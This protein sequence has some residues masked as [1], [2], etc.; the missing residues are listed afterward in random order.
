ML[1]KG[2][3]AISL[4]IWSFVSNAIPIALETKPHTTTVHMISDK[5][6]VEYNDTSVA[7]VWR[8]DYTEACPMIEMGNPE[9]RLIMRTARISE[10]ES[11]I[12]FCSLPN[13]CGVHNA[14][15]H[16]SN[17]TVS[18]VNPHTHI[19]KALE[20]IWLADFVIADS[21]SSNLWH[22]FMT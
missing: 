8:C 3:I 9:D 22:L 19:N 1:C 5:L 17:L 2:S 4:L 15:I 12:L 14:T 10:N 7:N 20:S 21:T 16:F 18:D 13:N 11:Y 6:P